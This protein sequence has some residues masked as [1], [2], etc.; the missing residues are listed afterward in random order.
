MEAN[1]KNINFRAI[2][3]NEFLTRS[4]NNSSYSIRSFAKSLGIESSSLSQILQGK[5]KLTDK[6]CQRLGLKL[7]FSLSKIQSLTKINTNLNE[8]FESFNKIKEDQFLVISDWYYYSILELT[9]CDEFQGNIRWISDVLDLPISKTIEAVSRLKRLGFLEISADGKWIDRLGDTNNLGNELKA[10]AFT[11]HQRQILCKATE[12]LEKTNYSD[13]VQ[14]SMT[15]AVSK[16]KVVEAKKIILSFIEELN[17]FLRS[18]QSKDEV[19][20]ISVSLYPTT[21]VRKYSSKN[22]KNM[23]KTNEQQGVQL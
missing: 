2:L 23:K 6:M 15:V 1:D 19:Y 9:Y 12:A 14:S 20:N 21:E 3:Q 10:P 8:S 22:T 5:R 16:E 13:R 4:K 7:G 18:G 11:E 17:E